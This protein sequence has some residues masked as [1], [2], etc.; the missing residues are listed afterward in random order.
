M[1]QLHNF[2]S[3]DRALAQLQELDDGDLSDLQILNVILLRILESLNGMQQSI[4]K[5]GA[6]K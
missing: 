1:T 3:T 2:N 4:L 5:V 6:V